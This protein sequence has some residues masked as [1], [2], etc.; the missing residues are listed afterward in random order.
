MALSGFAELTLEAR[1]LESLE[2]FY[3]EAFGLD[4]LSRDDDRI[5][6]EAGPDARLGLWTPGEKE[7]GDEG[8]RHVHFAFAASP[9]TLDDLVDRLRSFGASVRGPEQHPGGDR[10][11]YVEDPEGNVVEVWDFFHRGE[12]ARNGTEAFKGD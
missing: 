6:L 1:D 5:W 2:R 8:G 10:S 9:G 4:L 12:G 11:A 3:T 7:F